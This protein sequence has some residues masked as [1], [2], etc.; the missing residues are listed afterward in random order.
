MR[1]TSNRVTWLL[2]FT[3]LGLSVLTVQLYRLTV[4]QSAVWQEEAEHNRLRKLF[5][6]GPRGSIYDRKGRPLATSEP[7]LAAVLVE[8]DPDH[9]AKIMP[10]LSLLL[11]GGDTEKAREID[12]RVQ[13]RVWENKRNWSQYEPLTIGQNLPIQV[14]AEFVERR[15]EF[16]GVVLV[17]ES[18][19]VYPQGKLAGAL[20]GYVGRMGEKELADPAYKDYD[21]EE[22]VGKTGLELSYQEE[23]RGKRGV[24][25]VV[26]DNVGRPVSA[27]QNTVPAPGHNLHLTLDLDL[28]RVAEEA[29]IRQMA[30]IREKD[31]KAKPIRGALVV[32][33]VRTGAILAMASVPTYDPNLLVRG[34]TEQEWQALQSQPGFSMWNWAI[35]GFPP[36]STYKMATGMA[37]VETGAVGLWEQIDCPPVYWR[38]NNPRNWD[39]NPQ[40]PADLARAVALSCNPY[41]YESGYRTG[42]DRLAAF[43]EQFGFGHK[44]GVDLPGEFP[45]VNPTMESYGDRWQPG[46][47]TSVAIGQGDVLVTP[48]QLANYTATIAAG[49]VRYRPYLVA[50]VRDASGQVLRRTEPEELGRVQAAPETWQRVQ[51]GMR[52]G[53]SEP[54]GTAHLPMLGFPVAV[55]AKTGSAETGKGPANGLSVAYAPYDK[56]EIAVSVVIEGGSTGSWTTPVIRRV[57]AHYFGIQDQIP[58]VAPTYRD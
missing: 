52:M 45:G 53:V 46:T 2:L 50:E 20:V 16:P 44:T 49:G 17:T 41:F 48:L 19:R 29:L 5:N 39:P 22:I 34:M 42:V 3:V 30:W 26:I 58:K 1:E 47:I 38:F 25:E 27:F 21:L 57:M 37:G 31:P 55:A 9:V 8:Q 24:N 32:Q 54:Y 28:H 36:G 4:A 18:T 33:D 43:V 35:E 15:S 6:H 40:G 11:A 23:V 7:A 13:R 14:V 51:Q 10:R 56:P 12:A